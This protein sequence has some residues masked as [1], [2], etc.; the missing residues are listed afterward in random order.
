MVNDSGRRDLN[1]YW[2]SR[3]LIVILVFCALGLAFGFVLFKLI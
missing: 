3:L 2:R 1:P